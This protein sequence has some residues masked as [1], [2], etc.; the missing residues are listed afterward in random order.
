MIGVMNILIAD[1]HA[2]FRDGLSVLLQGLG[3]VHVAEARNRR[4]IEAHLK[5]EDLFDLLLLDLDMPGIINSDGVR[6]ICASA[7]QTAVVVISGND[8]GYVV[9][10]C[11]DAGAMG[12]ISKSSASKVMLAAIQMVLAGECYVPSKYFNNSSEHSPEATSEATSISPRQQQIWQMLIDGKSN[13]E[14]AIALDLTGSTVKQHVSA[15]F[16]KLG[17]NSRTQAVQKAHTI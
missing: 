4:E 12:F 5:R 2:L 3:P 8:A 16:R 9:K 14:I 6:H 10:G 15:L 11:L 13:K 7:P 17:V 1:D